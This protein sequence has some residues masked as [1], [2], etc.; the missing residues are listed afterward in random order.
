MGR[1]RRAKR[2]VGG[3]CA[4]VAALRCDGMQSGMGLGARGPRSPNYQMT[5]SGTPSQ[6][7][8]IGDVGRQMVG[9]RA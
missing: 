5:G 6:S 2:R 7:Q 9:R 4:K 8:G 1:M 3:V